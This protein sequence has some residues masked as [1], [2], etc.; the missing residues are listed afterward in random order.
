MPL[1][2]KVASKCRLVGLG[3]LY[4]PN[5]QKSHAR[6]RMTSTNQE[7]RSRHDPHNSSTNTSFKILLALVE[8]FGAGAGGTAAAVADSGSA[9]SA[10]S[11]AKLRGGGQTTFAGS[12]KSEP[13]SPASGR[14]ISGVPAAPW[15]T[16]QQQE[17]QFRVGGQSSAVSLPI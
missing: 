9:G 3:C 12:P 8:R 1:L 6:Y 16:P 7:T 4:T 15:H 11:S 14:A 17:E 10:D 13:S 2:G 5:A